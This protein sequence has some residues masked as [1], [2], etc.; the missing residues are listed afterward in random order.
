MSAKLNSDKN[1]RQG[2][3]KAG[4]RLQKEPQNDGRLLGLGGS[5]AKKPG[6]VCMAKRELYG[7]EYP[8]T[9]TGKK[10]GW[11]PQDVAKRREEGIRGLKKEMGRDIIEL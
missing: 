1:K 3:K 7:K 9:G 5:A 4:N 10:R 2:G 6:Q 8:W 11:Q